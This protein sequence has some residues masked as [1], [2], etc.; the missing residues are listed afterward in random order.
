ME[1][2]IK[3]VQEGELIV[4]PD[5]RSKL[6][7]D[8]LGTT[9]ALYNPETTLHS[10]E[11]LQLFH[12]SEAQYSEDGAFQLFCAADDLGLFDELSDILERPE[13]VN[14]E[15]VKQFYTICDMLAKKYCEKLGDPKQEFRVEVLKKI[16]HL[17]DPEIFAK[18]NLYAQKVYGQS[19]DM[20]MLTN[21]SPIM[22]EVYSQMLK[23]FGVTVM[24]AP[25][26][27]FQSLRKDN[28]ELYKLIA[29]YLRVHTPQMG[30][31][32]DSKK[33]V[34][35]GNLSGIKTQLFNAQGYPLD[36][37]PA[38]K[39]LKSETEQLIDKL[40]DQSTYEKI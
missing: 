27:A 11:E 4:E 34:V 21:A 31:I 25:D 7:F 38:K 14:M 30:L 17:A 3:N 33:N 39:W 23:G 37:E 15:P 35:A 10:E 28:P 1:K 18:A 13:I 40:F 2:D 32:D 6:F 22:K 29:K 19:I 9:V 26:K 36:S 5:V 8:A 24:T 20:F 16:Y 12:L